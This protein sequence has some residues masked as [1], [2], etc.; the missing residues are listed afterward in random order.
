MELIKLV[1]LNK[2]F[3]KGENRFSALNNVNL[4]IEKGDMVAI[5]GP[6]G[7]GKSTLLNIIGCL[8]SAT[9]GDYY[10]ENN[11]VSNIKSKELARIRNEVFGFVVQYFALID[12]YNVYENIKVPIEYSKKKVKKIK[13]KIGNLVNELGIG[14]KLKCYTN[15][16][17]GGESQRVA[18]ARA[19]VND[20]TVILADEPTGALDKKNGEEVMEIF[21]RLNN[22]GKT[23][24][25]VTHDS[26]IAEKCN[27]IIYIEDG[28]II[29]IKNNN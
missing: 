28:K 12:N 4:N 7:S 27:K 18:I 21:K 10:L 2:E 5:M 17:S 26:N 19:L 3:G 16:L 25:I 1:N 11:L 8:D 24:I 6:S 22:K 20:P 9:S 14:D 15:Q 23:I 13:E 29:K